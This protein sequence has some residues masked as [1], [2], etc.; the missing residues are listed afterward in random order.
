LSTNSTTAIRALSP[1][2]FGILNTLVYPPG[3]VA[4]R[5]LRGPN[6]LVMRSGCCTYIA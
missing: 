3:R 6:S 1:F 2:L 5:S 4:K